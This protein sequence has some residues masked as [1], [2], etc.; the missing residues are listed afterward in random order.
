VHRALGI[1]AAVRPL[2]LEIRSGLHTGECEL[3]GH[4]VSGIAVHIGARVAAAANAGEVLVSGTL[5]DLVTGSGHRFVD[6]GVHRLPPPKG[7][8][9]RVA[10]AFRRVASH[11]AAPLPAN[12]ALQSPRSSGGRDVS[13]TWKTHPGEHCEMELETKPVSVMLY[14][15]LQVWRSALKKSSV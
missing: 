1:R 11:I 9:W 10:V 8:G 4:D 15:E 5:K 6:R 14:T 2:G 12:G 13:E 7:R 3:R